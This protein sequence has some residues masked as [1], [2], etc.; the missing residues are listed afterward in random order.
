M[1]IANG[2]ATLAEYKTWISM[3]GQAGAVST[4]SSDDGV[5]EI[6]I[7]A[8]SRYI[9]R[10]TGRRFY[11]NGTDETRYYT[12]EDSFLVWTDDIG[13]L[14]SIAVDYAGDRTYTLLTASDYDLIP[15]NAALNG[16]PYN[17]IEI[18]RITGSY[19]PTT[20]RAVKVIGKFGYPAVPTDIKEACIAIAQGINATRSGQTS[21]GKVTVTSAGIVIRPEDVPAFAQKIIQHYRNM[22]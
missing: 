4:D 5:I 9:D 6:L 7:E 22:L 11:M 13:S 15:D 12:T 16:D 21:G 20:R 19:F 3:R 10:E 1:T 8:A 17:G 14:T 2:Y 18:N